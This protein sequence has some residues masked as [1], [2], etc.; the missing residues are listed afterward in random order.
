[1][2]FQWEYGFAL[3][4]PYGGAVCP[5]RIYDNVYSALMRICSG[6]MNLFAA[7]RNSAARIRCGLIF[8][9]AAVYIVNK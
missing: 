3:K 8:S 1:M 9:Q 4:T 6:R 5:T 2:I 7:N